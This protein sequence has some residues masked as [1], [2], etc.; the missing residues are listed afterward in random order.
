MFRING[1]EDS[2]AAT[3]QQAAA[4]LAELRHAQRL[5]GKR[6]AGQT[7]TVRSI[8]AQS[9]RVLRSG[10]LPRAI[11]KTIERTEEMCRRCKMPLPDQLRPQVYALLGDELRSNAKL[12]KMRLE[13]VV[14]ATVLNGDM[15][16][17]IESKEFMALRDTPWIFRE[18]ALHYVMNPLEYLR[19]VIRNVEELQTDEEFASLRDTPWMFRQA[20]AKRPTDPKG[21]LRTAML[22]VRELELDEEFAPLR[23]TPGVFRQAAVG[24]PSNPR[25]FLRRVIRNVGSLQEIGEFAHLRDTPWIFRAVAVGHPGNPKEFLREVVRTARELE[26]DPEFTTL[27][28]T[29]SVFREA[30][31]YHRNDP[32][33]YLRQLVPGMLRN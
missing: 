25:Q 30:A 12:F 26:I 28:A 29:P 6:L 33:A 19:G 7:R 17:L 9:A 21:F 13:K 32:R 20:A 11:R 14:S 31:V 1:N 2:P 5:R 10:R 15:T 23:D 8:A 16:A 24:W 27:R 4:F 22:A 3:L 18:A